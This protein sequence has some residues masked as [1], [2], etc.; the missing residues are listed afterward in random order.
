MSDFKKEEDLLS[1]NLFTMI[2]LG[3]LEEVS[4][5]TLSGG[6]IIGTTSIF[7]AARRLF[8]AN[9]RAALAGAALVAGSQILGYLNAT[10]ALAKQFNRDFPDYSLNDSMRWYESVFPTY[11]NMMKQ[12]EDQAAKQMVWRMQYLNMNYYQIP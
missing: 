11:D 10:D 3:V 5:A 9:S 4:L 2:S 7:D 6:G 8:V 1:R 12:C